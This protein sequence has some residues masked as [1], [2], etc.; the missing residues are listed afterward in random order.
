V[1]VS[2]GSSRRRGNSESTALGVHC[3]ARGF[4]SGQEGNGAFEVCT[5][6]DQ[7]IG[8]EEHTTRT[9]WTRFLDNET[10]RS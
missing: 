3:P 7:G 2:Y 4:S 1:R 5:L 6:G 8:H 10:E 9:G